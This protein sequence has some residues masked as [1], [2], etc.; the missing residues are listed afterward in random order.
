MDTLCLF[1]NKK[2][3]KWGIKNERKKSNTHTQYAPLNQLN[4]LHWLKAKTISMRIIKMN[5]DC[6]IGWCC[7]VYMYFSVCKCVCVCVCVCLLLTLTLSWQ[8]YIFFLLAHIIQEYTNA[9]A[10]TIHICV[11]NCHTPTHIDTGINTHTRERVSACTIYIIWSYALN[12]SNRYNAMLYTCCFCI[13]TEL[14]MC[15]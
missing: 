2:K 14:S 15:A 1:F 12:C 11:Q 3:K 13:C 8:K 4:V 5:C 9:P 6:D 10:F 7:V